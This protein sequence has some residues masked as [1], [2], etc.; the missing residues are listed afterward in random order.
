M[1]AASAAAA[2]AAA[3]VL[4]LRVCLT[5]ARQQLGRRMNFS[6]DD[7]CRMLQQL[8][9]GECIGTVSTTEC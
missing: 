6:K 2:A 1:L 5:A 9:V 7:V 8:A 3:T 4:F